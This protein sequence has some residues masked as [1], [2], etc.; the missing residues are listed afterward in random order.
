LAFLYN[1][2]KANM[3]KFKITVINIFVLIS[4]FSCNK[5]DNGTIPNNIYTGTRILLTDTEGAGFPTW[6]PDGN[7]IAFKQQDGALFI[8]NSNGTNKSLIKSWVT[9]RPQWSPNSNYLAYTDDR[10]S[11]INIYRIDVD[12]NNEKKLLKDSIMPDHLSWSPDGKMIAY[13]GMDSLFERKLY[14]MNNDGTNN[15]KVSTSVGGIFCPYWSK[16]GGKIMFSSYNSYNSVELYLV[17]TNGTNLKKLNIGSLSF[18]LDEPQLSTDG[19]TIYFSAFS[20]NGNQSIYKINV[21]G[22]GLTN[23]TNNI[24]FPERI[25]LSP[26]GSKLAF[27]RYLDN[28]NA[29]IIM[30]SDG[31][32]LI[33]INKYQY[34]ELGSWSPDGSKY[35]YSDQVD[36]ISGLYIIDVSD[37]KK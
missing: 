27:S 17:D 30:S 12:G 36:G 33:Q 20:L 15:H 11:W 26:D 21:D 18:S 7:K 3:I 2:K 14:I 34:A 1:P 25:Q 10:D 31:S 16:V 32:N 23:L 13:S 28:V 35:V 5:D 8:M 4:I 37:I 29:L 24:G 19:T 22:S 6:S 9:G